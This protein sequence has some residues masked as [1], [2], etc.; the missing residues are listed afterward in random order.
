MISFLSSSTF[1]RTRFQVGQCAQWLISECVRFVGSDNCNT[2]LHTRDGNTPAT[3]IPTIK[4]TPDGISAR[5]D[6]KRIMS[7]QQ[8]QPTVMSVFP[9]TSDVYYYEA[10]LLTSGRMIIGWATRESDFNRIE[11]KKNQ[12]FALDRFA[13]GFD[14]YER[15][16]YHA[17]NRIPVMISGNSG[18]NGNVHKWKEGDIVG[19]LIDIPERKFAFYLNRTTSRCS[20]TMLL[21]F[22]TRTV[23]L[24]SWP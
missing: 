2:G 21:Q 14:G 24:F 19:C 16:V 15:A 6:N 9:V 5:Y 10:T 23:P 12:Q 17:G 1:D 7:N 8:P 22:W 18:S 13:I 3:S 4:L 20:S 11:S